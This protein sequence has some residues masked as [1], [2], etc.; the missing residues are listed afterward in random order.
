MRRAQIEKQR[1]MRQRNLERATCQNLIYHVIICL[2][3]MMIALCGAVGKCM[4][5]PEDIVESQH[6]TTRP[7][8]IPTIQ[9]DTQEDEVKAEVVVPMR[10]VTYWQRLLW[11]K[12]KAATFRLKLWSL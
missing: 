9:V 2:F 8:P 1:R 6:E 11:Q 4:E 10:T 7:Q 3:I 12:L 5:N